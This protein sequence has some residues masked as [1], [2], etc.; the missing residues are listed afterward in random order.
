VPG[1]T[2]IGAHPHISGGGE[3]VVFDSDSGGAVVDVFRKDM[4]SGAIDLIS[5]AAGG[6]QGD[7]TADSISGDG[8]V[9]AFS[10]TAPNL[11][12]A[13]TNGT[14]DVFTRNMVSGAVTRVSTRNDGTQ[15]D[16]P[17]YAAAADGTGRY[18]AFASR[19]PGVVPGTAATARARIYRKDLFTG[20]VELA[21]TGV[22][23]A[24]R[25]LIDAPLGT[26]PRRKAR[27]IS[28]TVEDDG[29]VAKVEVSLWRSIGKG[30][31][32]WLA[33]GSRVVKGK[34]SQSVR[35]V[36]RLDNG[37]RFSLPIRHI[38]PRGTWQLRTRA[39][40][41]TGTVEPARAGRNAVSLK[42]V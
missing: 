31:C 17:S 38:L 11:V 10:S 5:A 16:G 23:L 33:P 18:I 42:L 27:T 9:V 40:D 22:D 4:A 41:Q 13:D 32:L 25:S 39:T 15:L 12:E 14:T 29:T 21:G 3:Y 19:A 35:I 2:G 37:L 8:N 34:C 1:S 6:A 26:M 20:A 24:P 7:S 30:R 28:G 36:A